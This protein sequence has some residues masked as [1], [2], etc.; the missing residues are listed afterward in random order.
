MTPLGRARGTLRASLS[1]EDL[2]RNRAS[3]PGRR[4]R[5]T[6]PRD[7]R[8][9][10]SRGQRPVS[11]SQREHPGPTQSKE[12]YGGPRRVPPASPGHCEPRGPA[13]G[14]PGR[15]PDTLLL[16]GGKGGGEA[17]RAAVR[18]GTPGEPPSEGPGSTPLGRL[19]PVR[20]GETANG[21]GPEPGSPQEGTQSARAPG[22][23]CQPR[24]PSSQRPTR[25]TC[26]APL[27]PQQA[28]PPGA[29]HGASCCPC[30]NHLSEG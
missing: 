24:A 2:V 12:G 3:I 18:G 5:C 1:F 11:R 27:T 17:P 9:L 20:M 7:R 21:G 19:L 14:Q 30:L 28:E 25:S 6:R 10:W 23:R 22:P 4:N 26:S 16:P 13:Q 15:V 8:P 29:W